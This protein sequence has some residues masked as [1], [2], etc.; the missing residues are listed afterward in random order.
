VRQVDPH[1]FVL[2]INTGEI[3]GNG[4]RSFN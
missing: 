3:V 4:F 1:A 2:I